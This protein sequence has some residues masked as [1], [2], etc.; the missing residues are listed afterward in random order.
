MYQ[1]HATATCS[2]RDLAS[3]LGK[4][5]FVLSK[6]ASVRVGAG[7]FEQAETLKGVSLRPKRSDFRLHFVVLF[8]DQVRFTIPCMAI[9]PDDIEQFLLSGQYNRAIETLA[10]RRNIPLDEARKRIK[11]RLLEVTVLQSGSAKAQE[12]PAGP[13]RWWLKR[14]NVKGSVIAIAGLWGK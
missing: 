10:R 1:H 4:T 8:S 6:I 13:W 14:K 12:P 5:A 11:D 3:N 2:R 7:L 9:L